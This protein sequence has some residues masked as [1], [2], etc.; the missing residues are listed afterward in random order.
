MDRHEL[1]RFRRSLAMLTPGQLALRRE[2]ALALLAEL[3]RVQERLELRRAELS[4]ASRSSDGR[5][6]LPAPAPTG[7]P[8]NN[9][10]QLSQALVDLRSSQS[11]RA[12]IRPR[13]RDRRSDYSAGLSSGT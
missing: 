8:G 7:G 4:P 12:D 9:K 11:R 5:L 2:D 6:D 3:E 13:H 1:E 10:S